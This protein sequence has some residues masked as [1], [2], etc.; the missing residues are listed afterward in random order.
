MCPVPCE[1]HFVSSHRAAKLYYKVLFLTVQKKKK[2]LNKSTLCKFRW[3]TA[4]LN[5]FTSLKSV[6]EMLFCNLGVSRFSYCLWTILGIFGRVH[7]LG[8]DCTPVF[9]VRVCVSRSL[10]LGKNLFPF[11]GYWDLCSWQAFQV[12]I[13]SSW[14]LTQTLALFACMK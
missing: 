11:H 9:C 12:V 10:I 4:F 1:H 13:V 14:M 2:N 7:S 8:A 5:Q 6:T 3:N